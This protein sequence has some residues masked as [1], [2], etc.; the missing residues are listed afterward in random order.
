MSSMLASSMC[1]K[2]DSKSRDFL[3]CVACF[4][5]SLCA[6]CATDEQTCMCCNQTLGYRRV[7]VA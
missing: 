6:D 5:I 7:F 1:L 3:A 2:C 4:H